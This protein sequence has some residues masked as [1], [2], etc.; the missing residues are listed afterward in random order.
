M[1]SEISVTHIPIAVIKIIFFR[2][3]MAILSSFFKPFA[4]GGR[5]LCE[6]D[7]HTKHNQQRR[8]SKGKVRKELKKEYEVLNL[9]RAAGNRKVR[10]TASK[11]IQILGNIIVRQY[12]RPD[13][14]HGTHLTV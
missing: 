14:G 7:V 2:F 11:M 8:G 4:S 9:L 3:Q 10:L 6:R 13:V 1:K 12:N 5:P